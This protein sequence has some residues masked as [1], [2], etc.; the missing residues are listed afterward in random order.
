M[1]IYLDMDDVVADWMGFA[2]TWLREPQWAEGQILP[3][4][5]WRRL[6]DAHRMY[7]DLPLKAGGH[8]LVEYCMSLYQ[9]GAVEGLYFLSAIPHNNDMPFA[10]YDKVLWAQHYFPGIPVFLGPYSED[11]WQRCNPGDVLIDD[12]RVNCE[13][14]AQAGGQSHIYRSWPEC[15]QWLDSIFAK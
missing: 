3:D 4:A 1:K 14:W 13:Q 15:K 10:P 2:R 7:R 11:K 8:E 5:T 9:A 6:K 12:R